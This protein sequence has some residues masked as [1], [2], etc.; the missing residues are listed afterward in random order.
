MKVKLT[1]IESPGDDIV[2]ALKVLGHAVDK[3]INSAL[4]PAR[5][6]VLVVDARQLGDPDGLAKRLGIVLDD[7]LALC[8]GGFVDVHARDVPRDARGGKRRQPGLVELRAHGRAAEG[9]AA[10]REWFDPF[11]PFLDAGLDVCDVAARVTAAVGLVKSKKD[12]RV[13]VG[14]G[15]AWGDVGG[16]VVVAPGIDWA[17]G[18]RQ[19][20]VAFA[21]E[22]R[23]ARD[24][25]RAGRDGWGYGLVVAVP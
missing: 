17:V 25:V 7:G 20:L 19:A 1:G 21:P 4:V 16:E 23:G 14:G 12:G 18:S 24:V 3:R 22:H 9:D 8:D 6:P 11:V 5:A 13:L 10:G 2:V 15:A